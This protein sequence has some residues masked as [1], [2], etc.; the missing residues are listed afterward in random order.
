MQ[1]QDD[2]GHDGAFFKTLLSEL[3]GASHKSKVLSRIKITGKS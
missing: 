2:S 1:G 3:R